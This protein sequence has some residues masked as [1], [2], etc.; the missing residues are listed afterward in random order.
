MQKIINNRFVVHQ[1]LG[2]GGFGSVFLVL[3]QNTNEI[4]ALKLIRPELSALNY[5]HVSFQKEAI[6]W[7]ECGNGHSAR[8]SIHRRPENC[9]GEVR[10]VITGLQ[11]LRRVFPKSRRFRRRKEQL[12]RVAVGVPVVTTG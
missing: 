2:E 3:D 11:R 1:K 10:A 7:M 5:L 12:P 6:I 9:H 8:C 4:C